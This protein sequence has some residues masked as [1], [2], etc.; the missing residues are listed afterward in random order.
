VTVH[1]NSDE[2]GDPKARFNNAGGIMSLQT[3]SSF[4]AV[5]ASYLSW[6]LQASYPINDF[7]LLV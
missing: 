5:T 6:H 7:E 1:P 3:A 2:S 4:P